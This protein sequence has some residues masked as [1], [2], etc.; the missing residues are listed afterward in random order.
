[1]TY[2]NFKKPP[3]P[4]IQKKPRFHPLFRK[5]IV[6]KATRGI[7]LIPPAILGLK[8]RVIIIEFE[9]LP[10]RQHFMKVKYLV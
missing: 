1:M 7:K 5:L 8:I 3:P 9:Y 4:L 10:I 6:G 2:D